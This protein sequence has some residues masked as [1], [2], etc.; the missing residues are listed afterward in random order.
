MGWNII[1]LADY[2][3]MQER[4]VVTSSEITAAAGVPRS[5][6]K[7]IYCSFDVHLSTT[8]GEGWG[9]TQAESMRCKIPNIVPD[10]SGLSEWA[11]GGVAY[12]PCTSTLVNTGGINTIGGIADKGLYIQE[13]NKMYYDPEYRS[14][15]AE[16]GYRLVSQEKFNWKNIAD[17]FDKAFMSTLRGNHRANSA[18]STDE[19]DKI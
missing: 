1:Q 9:L 19:S 18:T 5:F 11:R 3:N 2:Y 14:S 6:L 15:I 17:Q 4:L 16:A 10:W 7:N 12:V 13:L 8:L